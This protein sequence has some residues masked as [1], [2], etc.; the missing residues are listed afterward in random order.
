MCVDVG[1]RWLDATG[2]MLPLEGNRA[3]LKSPVIKPN[4]A[5]G[6]RLEV[7]APPVPGSYT[8]LVSMVQ[9]GV[10]WF[11]DRGSKPLLLQVTIS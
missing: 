10:A 1:Y 9:E 3:Q 5:D 8:L 2:K 11:F 6:V 4:E 7:T